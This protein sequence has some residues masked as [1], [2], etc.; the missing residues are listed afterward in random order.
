[1]IAY[2]LTPADSIQANTGPFTV[3]LFD[4]YVGTVLFFK[5]LDIT[6]Q[7]VCPHIAFIGYTFTESFRIHGRWLCHI[8]RPGYAFSQSLDRR[9][10]TDLFIRQSSFCGRCS[11]LLSRMSF[12]DSSFSTVRYICFIHFHFMTDH[13]C[14]TPYLR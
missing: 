1:M 2:K 10:D 5:R 7:T 12:N 3:A 9:E 6:P 13:I 14:Q 11:A 8:E 4:A